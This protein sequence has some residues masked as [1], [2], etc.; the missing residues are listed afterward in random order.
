MGRLNVFGVEMSCGIRVI[1]NV[2]EEIRHNMKYIPDRNPYETLMRGLGRCLYD[3][4]N[5]KGREGAAFVLF[6]DSV[7]GNEEDGDEGSGGIQL[8]E[9]IAEREDRFGTIEETPQAENTQTGNRIKMWTIVID[10]KT[11]RKWYYDIKH[12]QRS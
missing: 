2:N 4:L 12:A 6:S 10:N 3:D 9:Y 11:F 7:E 8:A 5:S 1:A